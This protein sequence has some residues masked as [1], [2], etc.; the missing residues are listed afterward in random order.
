MFVVDDGIV[1]AYVGI[2]LLYVEYGFEC[3]NKEVVM[4][5]EGKMKMFLK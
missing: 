3:I 1:F 5:M 2:D 4:W